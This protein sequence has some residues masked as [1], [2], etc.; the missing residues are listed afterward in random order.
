MLDDS[1]DSASS[2]DVKKKSAIPS[3]NQ[4]LGSV[5]TKYSFP[6]PTNTK[7]ATYNDDS[8]DNDILF[9]PTNSQGS[10]SGSPDYKNRLYNYADSP[11]KNANDDYLAN[12]VTESADLEDSILGGLLGG[13]KKTVRPAPAA[14]VKP[15]SPQ[16]KLEPIDANSSDYSSYNNS[17]KD[18]PTRDFTSAKA[19]QTSKASPRRSSPPKSYKASTFRSTSPTGDLKPIMSDDD[20][21]FPISPAFGMKRQNSAAE[22][23]DDKNFGAKRAEPVK[24]SFDGY[25]GSGFSSPG[26]KTRAQP[27]FD[28]T[29]DAGFLASLERDDELKASGIPVVKKFTDGLRP[30]TSTGRDA[31]PPAGA[32]SGFGGNVSGNDA[33]TAPKSADKEDD[34]EK[35]DTA[36]LAFIPSFLERGGQSRRRR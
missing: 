25:P 17:E 34:K 9:S 1:W 3:K 29:N 31:L 22:G 21:D 18:Y 33:L 28:V 27:S 2:P 4:K 26:Q 11:A 12:F 32:T 13:G 16:S 15:R 6:A 36:G 20:S 5:D 8:F 30:K 19:P 24:S 7:R 14:V 23:M 10:P 35:D